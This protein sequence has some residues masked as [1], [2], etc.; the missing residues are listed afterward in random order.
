MNKLNV[1]NNPYYK[2]RYPNC[3]VK[4]IKMFFHS[5]KYAYQRVT[6]GYA[7]CDTFDLDSYYLNIFNG[8]L[9]YL[10]DNHWGY[11]GNKEFDTD[12][13]WTAYLKEMANCFYR[14]NESNEFYDTPEA[15][16]WY[17]W[18]KEHPASWEEAEVNGVKLNQYNRAEGPYDKSMIEEE[19]ILSYRREKDMEKGIDMLKRVFFQLWD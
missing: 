17:E 16:K 9:N 10:A 13:K 1:F 3:W 18:I 12:E 8:T 7:D 5:F 19:K 4:N 2:W 14:A 6:K 11:P 15:D